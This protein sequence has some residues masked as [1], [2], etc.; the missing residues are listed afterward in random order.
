M[1][2]I[3]SFLLACL[4]SVTML[5]GLSINALGADQ[6]GMVNCDA[7][8]VRSGAGTSYSKIAVLYNGASV[9]VTGSANDSSGDKWYK[10]SFTYLGESKTGYVYAEYITV[11]SS[12]SSGSDSSSASDADFEKYMTAQG[13]PDS[14]K[15]MLRA[16][17]QKY[18]NW[19]FKAQQLNIDWNTALE[20][21]LVLGRNLVHAGAPASWKSMEKGAYNFSE[22]YW[23]GLDG[24]WVAASKEIIAYYLDPR[25]FINDPSIFM[26]EN[27]SYNSS[28]HT[29]SGVKNILSGTFMSG[30]F[31]TPDT[32]KTYSYAQTFMD[33]AAKSGVSPYHLAARCRNE[34]GVNGAPQSLGTVPGYLNYFNFFDINAYATSTMTAAQMGC[35][36]ASTTNPTYLL[37]WTNQYKSIVGGSIYVGNG[38]INKGQDTLYLQKFDM[39]DGGNGYFY[40]QYMTCV[41]GQENEAASLKK[42]YSQSML[43]S[44]MEFKIPVYKNMPEKIY[45]KPTSTGDNN[46]FLKSLSVSGSKLDKTFDKYTMSYSLTAPVTASSVTITAPALSSQAKVSGAGKVALKVGTNNIKI[47]VTA[48]SGVIRT[49]T[50]TIVRKAD[51]SYVAD[52][53]DFK[54]STTSDSVKLTWTKVS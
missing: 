12:G 2:K 10:I 34:Q 25:N 31:T 32:K 7:L 3:L 19:I 22:G 51:D 9:T 6:I 39:V 47:N 20:E 5:A 52:V 26:F 46:N 16:L 29:I 4:F 15:P 14:Y 37:P 40:H 28:V 11:T 18:P 21:E 38:Y 23:Y 43:N 54:G 8:N 1:K 27:L 41:F 42:A 13:F 45:P 50:V 17:H 53:T 24:S 36:Y 49:Y 44:A 48:P 30:N 35:K 33:A